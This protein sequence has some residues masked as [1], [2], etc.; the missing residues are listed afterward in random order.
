[1]MIL[2]KWS[3]YILGL[4]KKADIKENLPETQ[5]SAKYRYIEN[6]QTLVKLQISFLVIFWPLSPVC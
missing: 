2:K 3:H 1:M 6:I 5:I 4:V